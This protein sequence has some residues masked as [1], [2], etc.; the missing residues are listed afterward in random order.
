MRRKQSNAKSSL[1]LLSIVPALFVVC[2]AWGRPETSVSADSTARQLPPG[3]SALGYLEPLGRVI[4]LSGLAALE[5]TR[6]ELLL[7][8][9]GNTVRAGQI[10]AV[11]DV[12][13]T[14][15]AAGNESWH[16]H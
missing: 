1:W 15:K 11:L 2:W 9:E 5:P 14:K 7:V 4:K 13:G 8:K 3:V 6:I 16:H 12:F 10:L